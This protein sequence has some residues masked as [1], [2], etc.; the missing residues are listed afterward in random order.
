VTVTVTDGQLTEQTVTQ[1]TGTVGAWT[2][3]GLP[4]PGTYTV[5]LSRTDLAAQTI[6]VSMDAGGAVSPGSQAVIDAH[7]RIDVSMQANTQDVFGHVKQLG[8]STCNASTHGLAE[9]TVTLNSGASTYTT[10]TAGASEATCGEFYFG[11]IPPG[12]YTLTVNAGSATSTSSRVITVTAG[13]A[14][15]DVE[16]QL[17]AP[18]SV[19][20]RVVQ[21]SADGPGL[22]SWTVNLYLQAQYPTVVTATATTCAG[23]LPKDGSF[24]VSDIP[25]GTYV[26]EVRQT[27]GSAPV[28]SQTVFVQPS[29]AVNVGVI[30]VPSGG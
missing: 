29:A 27:P 24:Q 18:A 7:G 3:G 10:T 8:A 11:A 6:S 20:G 19:T 13:G 30:V 9:A 25:A 21:G 22:C 5:T 28:T 23:G 16:V 12:T 15:Q 1:S 2:A 17:A 4:V 14:P 26:V